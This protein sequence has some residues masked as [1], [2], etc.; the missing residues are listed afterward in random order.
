MQIQVNDIHKMWM[1]MIN[2]K[3]PMENT[4]SFQ[5]LIE[6]QNIFIYGKKIII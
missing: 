4:D 6:L 1:T 3:K 5:L 2:E